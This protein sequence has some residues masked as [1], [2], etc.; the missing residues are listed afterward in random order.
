MKSVPSTHHPQVS[1][2]VGALLFVYLSLSVYLKTCIKISLPPPPHAS[3]NVNYNSSNTFLLIPHHGYLRYRIQHTAYCIQYRNTAYRIQYRILHAAY[4]IPH[5]ILGVKRV[6]IFGRVRV[7]VGSRF[8]NLG[9]AGPG[10]GP[11]PL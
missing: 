10:P 1:V 2:S 3:Q 8:Q 7:R 11:G 4:R 9:P 5:P 6:R